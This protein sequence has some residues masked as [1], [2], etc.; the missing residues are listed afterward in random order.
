[1]EPE[2]DKDD[3]EE[4]EAPFPKADNPYAKRL[5]YFEAGFEKFPGCTLAAALVAV[6]IAL[7]YVL[8]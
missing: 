4:E 2:E 6:L 5:A 7:L 3:Q 1:M 8:S